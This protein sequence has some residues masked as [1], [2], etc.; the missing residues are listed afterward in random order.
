MNLS[1]TEIDNRLREAGYCSNKKIDYA[2][3][4]SLLTNRPLLVEGAPGVGKTYLAE[5]VAKALGRKFIRVQM[6]DGLTDDKILYDYNYQKQ[7]LSIE[8]IRPVLEKEM[9]GKNIKEAL[10]CVSHE[11][12]FYGKDFLIKRPVLSAIAPDD[13]KPCVLLFDEIDKASEETEYMLYEVL[14]NYSISIPEYGTVT[15]KEE[16]K[17]L[18]FLTSNAYRELSG[19]LKRRCA[20]LYIEQKTKKELIE[21][22]MAKAGVDESLADSVAKVLLSASS[23]PMH[24]YPSVSE[25]IEWAN[26]LQE[27][28]ERTR[29]YV[30]GTLAIMLKDHRDE[31]AL[32][33]AALENGTELWN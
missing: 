9:E 20:Y 23:K 17:P 8:A 5:S 14:E 15:A 10:D 32:A 31:E 30:I 25:G 4:V 6:Y 7:L 22:L 33:Q 29:E 19:A 26:V 28:P 18:V 2:L 27:N 11:A 21:I 24:E 16:E 3:Y 12:S 1:S 13:H